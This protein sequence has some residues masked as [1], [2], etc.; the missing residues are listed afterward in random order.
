MIVHAE[1]QQVG[2]DDDSVVRADDDQTV[3]VVEAGGLLGRDCTRVY[4]LL[5]AGDLVAAPE[6]EDGAGPVR[7]LRASLERWWPAARAALE[8]LAIVAYVLRTKL[9]SNQ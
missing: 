5:R 8:V 6:D 4:A 9:R 1:P 3:S 7:I 2:V